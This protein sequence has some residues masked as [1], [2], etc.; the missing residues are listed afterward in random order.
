MS[1]GAFAAAAAL[2]SMGG[3]SLY[4]YHNSS[5]SHAAPWVNAAAFNAAAFIRFG[6]LDCDTAE[7]CGEMLRRSDI[8]WDLLAGGTTP[9]YS[10]VLYTAALGRERDGLYMRGSDPL[11][12]VAWDGVTWRE[13]M[14]ESLDAGGARDCGGE[15]VEL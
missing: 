1:R 7:A 3:P 14:K 6:G 13:I 15:T 9:P 12:G 11:G 10:V 5:G 8:A 2:I 4:V